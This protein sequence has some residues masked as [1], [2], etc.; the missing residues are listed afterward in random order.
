M[1][2]LIFE[3][4]EQNE[5]IGLN[6]ETLEIWKKTLEESDADKYRQR[7]YTEVIPRDYSSYTPGE[8]IGTLTIT[9]PSKPLINKFTL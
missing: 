7:M 1:L 6:S 4:T 9:N 5:I 8:V 2:M 3:V